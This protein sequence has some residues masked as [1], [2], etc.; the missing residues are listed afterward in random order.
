M[1][2]SS[3]TNWALLPRVIEHARLAVR[4]LRE[5]GVPW[6][7]K[8]ALGAPFAYLLWPVDLI[9]DLLPVAGQIDDLAVLLLAVDRIIALCPQPLVDFHRSAIR[10][11]APYAPAGEA[12]AQH[13]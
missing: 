9:P 3:W 12:S 2:R 1:A 8:A 13:R 7:L 10:R 4:L 6:W 5:P 11:G